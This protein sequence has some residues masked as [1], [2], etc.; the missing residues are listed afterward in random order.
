MKKA[1]G[2]FLCLAMLIMSFSG[3]LAESGDFLST[4]EWDAEF[5]VV[6]AGFGIAGASTAVT[7]ADAGANVLVLEK[8]PKAEAGGNSIMCMQ[9]V[10]ISTDREGTIKYM[11]GMRGT[12][13]TPSDSMIEAYVDE[14]SHNL[15]WVTEQG[16]TN[17][18]VIEGH[19]EYPEM[20]GSSTLP[21]LTVDG[22]PG[23][24]GVAYKLISSNAEKKENVEVWYE[25]PAVKLIQDPATRIIHGVVAEVD[26]RRVN[27]R[28][29]NGVV[30]CTGGYESNPE[31][32]E[33]FTNES[34]VYSL[35]HAIYNTGDGVRMAQEVG[36]KLWHMGHIVGHFDFVD[37]ETL[38][39]PFRLAPKV[40][41][42]G[43]IFVGPDATRFMDETYAYHH[44]KYNFH[45]SWINMP[46]PQIMWMVFDENV[47]NQGPLFGSFSADGSEEIAKGWII[48][49]DSI[50][51]LAGK[52]DL[53]A[54]AL[55]ATLTEYNGI[56]E[57]GFD[58]YFGRDVRYLLSMNLEG[59][60]YAMPLFQSI[61]NTMGGPERNERGEVVA[62]DGTV[63]PHLYEAGELGDIW[64]NGYQA[65]CNFGGGMAFGRISGRNAAEVK[66]DVSQES[67]MGDREN[68]APAAAADF[69][70]TI[71]T[72]ANQY[73]GK[74]T[75]H[76]AT[77]LYVVV[78]LDDNKISAVD[79]LEHSE[80]PGVGDAAIE[81]LPSEIIAANSADVDSVTGA[82][83]TSDAIREAVNDALAKVGEVAI[84]DREVV[85]NAK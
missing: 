21:Y 79:I 39:A 38:Y 2:L 69:E 35:G 8:A 1:L 84:D 83:M 68:F 41:N 11:Q 34:K 23:G 81:K 61:V 52:I 37:E 32:L 73:W 7:A 33:N 82:T 47:M 49:G 53:D 75:G 10:C 48:E 26:G 17:P 58:N 62:I 24:N 9:Y 64:S 16:A 13:S 59:K 36:A 12:F 5:D 43:A 51:D 55:T 85:E 15:E 30:L 71:V 18:V 14:I 78:T 57:A 56:C 28:A 65:G 54:D 3:T 77:P 76:G 74:G 63:I 31:M 20:E 67:V 44:G 25:A 50:A 27:I 60:F 29:K 46:H 45:G 40:A 72:G 19:A 70:N 42:M 6:V 80:T 66:T 4:I 22:T